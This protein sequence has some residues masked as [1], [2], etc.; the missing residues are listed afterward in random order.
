MTQAIGVTNSSTTPSDFFEGASQKAV[1]QAMTGQNPHAFRVARAQ[2]DDEGLTPSVRVAGP[3]ERTLEEM[4]SL[5][6]TF[7]QHEAVTGL[8][9]TASYFHL[10]KTY[11]AL[12]AKDQAKVQAIDAYLRNKIDSGKYVDSADTAVQMLQELEKRLQLKE[13]HD[14]YYK[15]ERLENYLKTMNDYQK[16]EMI[17]PRFTKHALETKK[18]VDQGIKRVEDKIA[19]LPTADTSKIEKKVASLEKTTKEIAQKVGQPDLSGVESKVAQVAA[20][21]QAHAEHLS[22]KVDALMNIAKFAI[23]HSAQTASKVERAMQQ[24]VA[25]QQR[26]SSIRDSL[27]KLLQ[28]S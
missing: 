26:N 17:K 2:L 6:P 25:V 18:V 11:K 20:S 16:H 24:T 9:F 14:P 10:D 19:K 21:S 13:Y 8:P 7:L 5:E 15:I 22:Q 23:I 3:T 1:E 28:E 27:T 12:D 4:T